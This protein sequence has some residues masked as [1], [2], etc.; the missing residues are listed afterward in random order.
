MASSYAQQEE[1]GGMSPDAP[2]AGLA[3]F[4][5]RNQEGDQ[6]ISE[7][8]TASTQIACDYGRTGCSGIRPG[9]SV[10]TNASFL[11]ERDDEQTYDAATARATS[12]ARGGPICEI[13]Q[14]R[15]RRAR[16]GNTRDTR[17]DG[18]RNRASCL[19]RRTHERASGTGTPRRRHRRWGLGSAKSQ[20][21]S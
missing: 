20:A 9:C 11:R 21:S 12:R 2:D 8:L 16:A 15:E 7:S 10:T 14:V 13:S 17:R 3:Y 19:R 4:E 1:T 6:G 5:R 18:G